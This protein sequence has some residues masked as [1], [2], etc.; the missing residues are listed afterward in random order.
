MFGELSFG[1]D[2]DF[3][4]ILSKKFGNEFYLKNILQYGEYLTQTY[5]NNC[6]DMMINIADLNE[7]ETIDTLRFMVEVTYFKF[8]TCLFYSVS[9]IFEC[10][11]NVVKIFLSKYWNITYMIV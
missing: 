1:E 11:L 3:H 5:L 10:D 6:L 7:N 4:S 8:K 9:S 2:L